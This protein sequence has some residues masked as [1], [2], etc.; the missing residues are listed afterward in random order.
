[1]IHESSGMRTAAD[2]TTL[3]WRRWTPVEPR[4]VVILVH[5]LAEHGGRYTHVGEMLAGRGFDV[6][7]TD[8]R[9]FGASAGAR[10][11]VSSFAEYCSDLA[12]DMTDARTLDVPVV[13]LGHSLGGLIATLYAAADLPQPDLLVLSAPAL[14]AR[15]PRL[16]MLAARALVRIAPRLKVSNPVAGEQLSRDPAVGERYFADPLVFPKSTIGLG[17]AIVQAMAQARE[18][19]SEI[20]LPTLVIHG[21][22][23]T[24]VLPEF[25]EPLEALPNMTRILFDEFRHESFNEEGGVRAVATVAD[26]IDSRLK[27]QP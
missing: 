14:D 19:L 22:E 4:A 25:S 15:L 27:T 2:G 18:S 24:I 23:D 8:L 11:H 5:G 12:E 9:G 1:M 6:R 26:W 16:Q 21:G 10:A 13:L 20:K 3:M 17:V 7:V